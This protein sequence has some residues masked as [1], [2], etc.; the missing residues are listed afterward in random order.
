MTYEQPKLNHDSEK[1]KNAQMA[2]LALLKAYNLKEIDHW[3]TLKDGLRIR[4]SEIGEGKPVFV[5]PGNTGDMFPFIPLLSELNG[6]KFFIFNRPG[7]GLSDGMN[8]EKV[9]NIREFVVNIIDEVLDKLELDKVDFMAHSMGCHWSLWYAMSHPERIH[10]MNLIANPGRVMLEKIPL[11]LK[12]MTLPIIGNIAVKAL[13]PKKR[14]QALNGLRRMGTSDTALK[15]MPQE[16][17]EC[18]YYFQNLPNYQMSTLSLLKTFNAKAENAIN[19]KELESISI[20]IQ[21]IWGENDTFA[22]IEQGEKIAKSFP[23]GQFKLIKDA[24]HMP[25]IDQPKAVAEAVKTF[26][27][28]K[29]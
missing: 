6:Y 20:P 19:G 25:W 27:N 18:Y 1:F 21:L 13:V 17:S 12:A 11:P 7:G 15:K 9:N 14:S 3:F 10:S 23:I 29:L 16:F 4:V 26:L 22:S 24:G 2:E 5:V 8:H 28:T